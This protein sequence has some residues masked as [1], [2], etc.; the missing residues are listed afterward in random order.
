MNHEMK[1]EQAEILALKAL[2]YLAGQEDD[3]C[4]F[5]AL[6]GMAAGDMMERASDP[7]LLAGILDFFLSN[8]A[9]LTAFCDAHAI[10]PEDPACAR[11]TLPGGGLPHWT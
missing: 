7:E 2:T 4:R 8:E 3:M 5:V 10:N 6:S 1:H 11:R 9:L